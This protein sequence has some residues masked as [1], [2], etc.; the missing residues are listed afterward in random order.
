MMLLFGRNAVSGASR[1]NEDYGKSAL[2]M[3]TSG[4]NG[5]HERTVFFR[6]H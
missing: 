1:K 6:D 5:E 2:Q 3:F 4:A